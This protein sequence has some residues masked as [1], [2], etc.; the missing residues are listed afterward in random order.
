MSRL[1]ANRNHSWKKGSPDGSQD[2]PALGAEGVRGVLGALRYHEAEAR[3]T[4]KDGRHMDL[5]PVRAGTSLWNKCSPARG[6]ERGHGNGHS[7]LQLLWG[8]PD[9]KVNFAKF[10]E[11][12]DWQGW[13][14]AKINE[15]LG[16]F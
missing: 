6:G 5:R 9:S 11:D 10:Q 1:V 16:T 13:G 15:Q 3:V 7:C 14:E 2:R 8:E 4:D 12:G